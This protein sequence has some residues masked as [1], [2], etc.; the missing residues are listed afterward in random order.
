MT[1]SAALVRLGVLA[2]SSNVGALAIDRAAGPVNYEVAFGT[3]LAGE[4]LAQRL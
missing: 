3:H 4:R 1:V 2:I